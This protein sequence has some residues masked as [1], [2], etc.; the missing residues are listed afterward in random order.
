MTTVHRDPSALEAPVLVRMFDKAQKAWQV[1]SQSWQAAAHLGPIGLALWVIH[2]VGWS[3]INANTLLLEYGTFP[4]SPA[5][6]VPD[7]SKGQGQCREYKGAVSV[8]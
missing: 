6:M 7:Q 2:W 8:L 3:F 5:G 1:S 4:Q